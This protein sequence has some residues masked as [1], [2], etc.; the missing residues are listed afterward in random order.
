MVFF[1]IIAAYTNDFI[2][3]VDGKLPWKCPEDM[4]HFREVTC[5]VTKRS[6]GASLS[7]VDG[8]ELEWEMHN[9]VVMGYRTY[10]SIGGYLPGRYNFV[11]DRESSVGSDGFVFDP[12]TWNYRVRTLG[13]ALRILH[14]NYTLGLYVQNAFIIGGAKIYEEFFRDYMYDYYI[15][16]MHITR[17]GPGAK[18]DLSGGVGDPSRVSRFPF[19]EAFR[20]SVRVNNVQGTGVVGCDDIYN[21]CWILRSVRRS[22]ETGNEYRVYNGIDVLGYKFYSDEREY[23]QLIYDVMKEGVRCGDRTGVGTVSKFGAQIRFSL[24]DGTL[25]LLTTKKMFT[26]GVVEELLW[27][28]RGETDS[29][30]LEEKGVGIWKGNTSREALDRL[31]LTDYAEGEGGPIYGHQFRAFGG[32]WKVRC[33]DGETRVGGRA[34]DGYEGIDQVE[35]VIRL[36]REEP[37]SRRI[38]INL[39]NPVDLDAMALPPCHMIY[40][41]R[42]YNGKLSC[43][44]YQRSCDTFLGLPFNICSTALMTYIF[45]K[46]TGL[47][48]DEIV[49]SIGDAHIY[50][51]HIDQVKTQL[52]RAPLC[53]PKLA[54]ADRGQKC[55]E[56][57]RADDFVVMGY[58]SHPAIAGQMAV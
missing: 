52:K 47:V 56:D 6:V 30:I 1:H 43:S 58:E 49:I 57:F 17:M 32:K 9:A 27:F 19:M 40:Q 37:N 5:R 28:L 2:C 42:V 16:N 48:P 53:F 34:R 18:V 21:D 29:K 31:G 35:E 20:K 55:V 36:L 26:R 11:I 46:L 10:Q 4:R 54:I 25:P 23:L 39:W 41:F 14:G 22:V 33:V 3:G 24:R 12:E 51:N 44:M 38:L 50:Q 13:D 7:G 15:Q 45:G 8:E